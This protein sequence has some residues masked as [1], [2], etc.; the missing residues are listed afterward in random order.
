MYPE[1]TLISVHILKECS[2]PRTVI[3]REEEEE[4]DGCGILTN[5][6]NSNTPEREPRTATGDKR[7]EHE[8]EYENE[9]GCHTLPA[10]WADPAVV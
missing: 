5:L 8:N 9:M 7:H 2:T 10:N 4:Q 6:L 3:T 1:D